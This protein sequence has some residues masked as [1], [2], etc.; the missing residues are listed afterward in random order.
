MHNLCTCWSFARNLA[1]LLFYCSHNLYPFDFRSVSCIVSYFRLLVL[2]CL[3]SL[4]QSL[5]YLFYEVGLDSLY[6]VIHQLTYRY[7]SINHPFVTSNILDQVNDF[8]K[9]YS[10]F[11][12]KIQ[13]SMNTANIIHFR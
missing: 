9:S 6:S 10:S 11:N 5:K 1:A 3:L 4:I 2:P 8:S 13:L 7:W 12:S